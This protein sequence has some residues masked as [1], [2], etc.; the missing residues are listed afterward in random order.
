MM[1]EVNMNVATYIKFDDITNALVEVKPTRLALNGFEQDSA[2]NNNQRAPNLPL[3]D[4][5]FKV[6]LA[7]NNAIDRL[8]NGPVGQP[9]SP[10][11][12]QTPALGK[13]FEHLQ[14]LLPP[15]QAWRAFSFSQGGKSNV[16]LLKQT[17]LPLA[18]SLR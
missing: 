5:S 8:Q 4:T 13:Y 11:S 2:S 16:N 1:T 6:Q 12:Q 9:I 10:A 15:L 3:L 18:R 17:T 14:L 7:F